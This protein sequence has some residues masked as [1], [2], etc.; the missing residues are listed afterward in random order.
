MRPSLWY[1]NQPSS[2][3]RGEGRLACPSLYL[4]GPALSH[5]L[6]PTMGVSRTCPD[7]NTQSQITLPTSPRRAPQELDYDSPTNRRLASARP[8]AS[9][10]RHHPSQFS[11]QPSEGCL[12]TRVADKETKAPDC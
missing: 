8:C 12:Y 5:Q 1:F 2:K 10:Q 7:P 4:F 11:L 9:P 6:E 3:A